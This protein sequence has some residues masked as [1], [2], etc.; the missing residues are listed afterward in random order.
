[1]ATCNYCGGQVSTWAQKH[2][3]QDCAEYLLSKNA[4]LAAEIEQLKRE[5]H[6]ATG[7]RQAL[8]L[9]LQIVQ[10]QLEQA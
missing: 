2:D 10:A 6:I 9:E 5:L 7:S 3:M 8:A 4:R 1:M